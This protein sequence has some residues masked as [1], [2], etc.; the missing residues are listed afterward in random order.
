MQQN[1]KV[2]FTCM[3][4]Y[5]VCTHCKVYLIYTCVCIHRDR[6]VYRHRHVR[7]CVSCRKEAHRSLTLIQQAIKCLLNE[8]ISQH[9]WCT[10]QYH[11]W[12]VIN[13]SKY[14]SHPH[15][16]SSHSS[17]RQTHVKIND[18]TR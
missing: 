9:L 8:R 6:C 4:V 10:F 7:V 1:T 14:S 2:S 18:T 13:T 12:L 17:K 15:L 16:Q 3:H 11:K 5:I